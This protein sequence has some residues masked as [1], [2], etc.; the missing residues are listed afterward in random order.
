MNTK[1]KKNKDLQGDKIIADC[2]NAGCKTYYTKPKQ[3]N[4]KN[5]WDKGYFSQL[6]N[7][8]TSADFSADEESNEL[9]EIKNYC[10][11]KKGKL[12]KAKSNYIDSRTPAEKKADSKIKSMTTATEPKKD[13]K[14]EKPKRDGIYR[15]G[16]YEGRYQLCKKCRN[17]IWD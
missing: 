10:S 3:P 17:K 6:V 16:K 11:C 15:V 8:H 7:I 2:L 13:C 9:K 5:C 14:C 12:L 4:C 1:P